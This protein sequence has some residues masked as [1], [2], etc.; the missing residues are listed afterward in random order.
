MAKRSGC[1]LGE[2]KARRSDCGDYDDPIPDYVSLD[3]MKG[4]IGATLALIYPPGIGVVVP[5]ERWDDRAQP[6]LDYFMAFSGIVQPVS[7]LQ[8]RGP[9]RLP[10]A[11]R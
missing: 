10:G 5:G 9:G 1:D 3:E 11:D 2:S 4:R 8:L 6:M 7:R